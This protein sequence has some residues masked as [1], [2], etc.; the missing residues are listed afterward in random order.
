MSDHISVRSVLTTVTDELEKDPKR[1]FSFA[2]V[3]YV[4]MWYTRQS[5]E[6]KERFK[7]LV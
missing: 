4:Q 5:P 1:K 2:E 6:T 3:K 7:K